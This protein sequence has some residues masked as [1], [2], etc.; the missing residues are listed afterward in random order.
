MGDRDRTG[1]NI[2]SWYPDSGFWLVK[3]I[4]GLTQLEMLK[5]WTVLTTIISV[6]GML[7]V[8]VLSWVVP[9]V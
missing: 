6:T 2:F 3:E 7:V 8:L 5:A 4:S 1:G 9:L